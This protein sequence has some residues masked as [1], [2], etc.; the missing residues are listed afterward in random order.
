MIREAIRGLIAGR[1]LSFDESSAVMDELMSGVATPAQVG[2][3][4]TA[5]RMKGEDTEEIAGMAHVMREKSLHVKVSGSLV[6][7]CGTGGD[8]QGTFNISTA[9]AFV[10]AGAGVKVAKHGNRAASSAC[11]SAD[12]LEACGVKVELGPDEVERCIRDVG[13]G[14]MFA[15]VFHPAMRHVSGP[16]REI[17]VRTIFNF[18]GPLT[19]PAGAQH[20]VLGVADGKMCERLALVLLRLGSTHALIVHGEDQMDELTLSGLTHVW[21]VAGGKVREYTINPEDVGL[22]RAGLDAIKGG[23]IQ[24]NRILLEKVLAGEDGPL[25]DVVLLNAAAALV[26]A[27]KVTGFGDG[28]VL[29]AES[30]DTGRAEQKLRD[31]AR[32]SQLTE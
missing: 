12:V 14:F 29:A 17:G 8:G 11:G 22:P 19:N 23:D 15:P 1:S 31:L 7:T 30:V 26:A 16:R 27:D 28:I 21:D 3:F 20:Q 4:L 13:I 6:D 32:L 24:Q 5:L 25:R 18:L 10:V 9:T 2:S